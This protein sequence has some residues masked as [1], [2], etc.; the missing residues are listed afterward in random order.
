M[1]SLAEMRRGRSW[2]RTRPK[3][4]HLQTRGEINLSLIGVATPCDELGEMMSAGD[5]KAERIRKQSERLSARDERQRD[6]MRA[7][8]D[9]EKRRVAIAAKTIRLREQ[10]LAR[11][12]IEREAAEREAA[13]KKPGPA[14]KTRRRSPIDRDRLAA[15]SD[16]RGASSVVS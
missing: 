3:E 1:P 8:I 2:L 5:S 15:A 13:A 7:V 16:G 11:E 4:G 9:D 12:A 10:R 6:A 14:K